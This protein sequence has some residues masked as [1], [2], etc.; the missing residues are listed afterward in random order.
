MRRGRNHPS[1]LC[2]GPILDALSLGFWA[3]RQV[4]P[5]QLGWWGTVLYVD[6]AQR[7][8]PFEMFSEAGQVW[9]RYCTGVGISGCWAI[10]RKE[11]FG[12]MQLS[13]K[14]FHRHTES[15]PWAKPRRGAG[16]T[17]REFRARGHCLRPRGTRSRIICIRDADSHTSGRPLGA[18]SI[19]GATNRITM[20]G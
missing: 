8:R 16:R 12:R 19:T 6:K 7:A 18:M 5:S 9:P 11:G 2:R 1:P 13:R 15:L 10:C 20:E 3:P 14:S 4:S 17:G